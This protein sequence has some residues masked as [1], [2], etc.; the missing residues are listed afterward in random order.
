MVKQWH[1]NLQVEP[2]LLDFCGA[3]PGGCY[4]SSYSLQCAGLGTMW[5]ERTLPLSLL[6]L[7]KKLVNRRHEQ[8]KSFVDF[9]EFQEPVFPVECPRRLSHRRQ[10]LSMRFARSV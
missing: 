1:V 9:G 7:V 8:E 2:R 4:A 10:H 6:F 3:Q 5:T